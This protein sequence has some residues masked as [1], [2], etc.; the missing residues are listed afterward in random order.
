MKP[1][2][3]S[4]E[5]YIVLALLAK[6]LGLSEWITPETIAT[7]QEQVVDV[8]SQLHNIAVSDDK[9]IY[10]VAMIYVAGRQFLKW[11]EAGK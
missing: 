6:P 11:R 8:A 2:V 10:L 4:T 3:K 5:L 7:T 1:G 9:Y